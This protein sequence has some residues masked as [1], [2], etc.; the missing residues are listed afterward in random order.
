VQLSKDELMIIQ[1]LRGIKYGSITVHIVAEKPVRMET[2]N[3]EMVR[4]Q[5]ESNITIAFEV[6]K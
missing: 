4:D 1:K 5:E 3:S 6:V 2:T